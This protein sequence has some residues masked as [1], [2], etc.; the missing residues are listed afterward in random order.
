[1]VGKG[2]VKAVYKNN[3]NGK[4]WVKFILEDDGASQSY[5]AFGKV[6]P[7]AAELSRGDQVEVTFMPGDLG[8]IATKVVKLGG[9]SITPSGTSGTSGTSSQAP[10]GYKG[11][12][13]AER[14]EERN[15]FILAR[16]ILDTRLGSKAGEKSREETRRLLLDSFED[17]DEVLAILEDGGL[18]PLDQAEKA[19][20]SAATMA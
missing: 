11:G 12:A 13:Y 16:Y 4:D 20:E 15:R 7:F 8:P 2:T 5:A 19:I 6:V 1:M 14:N 9:A 10:A 3:K 17:A 18:S